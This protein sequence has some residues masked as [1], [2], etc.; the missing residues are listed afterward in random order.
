[1]RTTHHCRCALRLTGTLFGKPFLKSAKTRSSEA[2]EKIKR[3]LEQNEEPKPPPRIVTIKAALDT[4]IKDCG[5]RNLNR[6]K[7][8]IKPPQA[9]PNPTLPYTDTE[10]EKI[11]AASSLKEPVF[12]RVMLHRGLGILD[13]L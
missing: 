5:A 1:M 11:M 13:A 6:S 3:K 7:L 9:K 12:Y 4:F 2:A 8:A 10:I